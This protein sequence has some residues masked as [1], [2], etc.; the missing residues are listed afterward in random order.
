MAIG[1]AV[2][3]EIAGPPDYPELR[4]EGLALRPWDDE[5]IASALG[6]Q[7]HAFPYQAFNLGH[8]LDVGR[9]A[10]LL[11]N[12]RAPGRHRHYA[13]VEG[14]VPVGRVSVNLEDPAGL[15]LWSV[16]VPPDHEGRGVCRRMLAVMIS[17]LEYRHPTRS[18]L[19][20][21]SAF[22]LHAHRAYFALGFRI[23]DAVWR[24]DAELQDAW[25]SATTDQQEAVRDHVRTVDGQ[26]ETRTYIMRRRRGA[27]MDTGTGARPDASE[28]SDLQFVDHLNYPWHA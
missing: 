21:S 16:H 1:A 20:N 7:D 2:R 17:W 24:Q 26:M 4:G 19:L 3:V 10:E 15:Y 18:C 11:A 6:W 23:T 22:S 13:A 5:L 14:G 27:R 28:S 12:A 25:R 9:A 8:T